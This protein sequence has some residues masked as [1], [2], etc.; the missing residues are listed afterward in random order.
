MTER[1]SAANRLDKAWWL[2][3]ALIATALY[4]AHW[5]DSFIGDDFDLIHSFHGKPTSYFPALLWNNESGDVWKSWGIDPELGRGYLRPIKIWLLAAEFTIWN[6]QAFGFHLTS[7]ACFVA[8]VLLVFAI[9]RRIVPERPVV[10]AAGAC[11]TAVHPIFAE[12]VPFITARE[13]LLAT[14]FGLASFFTFLRHRDRDSSPITFHL[15]YAC[16]LLTKE[17]AIVFLALPLG[18]D[19]VDGRLWPI[20]RSV[21]RD[22]F[23]T[24]A[25]SAGILTVYFALRW[26]AFGN[27]VG[28]DGYPVHYASWSA[29][30]GFHQQFWRSLVDPTLFTPGS[31]PWVGPVSAALALGLLTLVA[32]NFGNLPDQRRRDLWVLGPI[33]Y[34]GSTAILYG[35]YF[36]VRHHLLPIVG[37]VLFATVLID[38]LSVGRSSPASWK[39]PLAIL[40]VTA[41][42]F[43]PPTLRTSAD[44]RSA[45]SAVA[46]IRAEIEV[47][48]AELKAPCA[49]RLSGVPQWI[50]P[51]FYF[52]WGLQ[53]AL[54]RPFTD[55]DLAAVCTVI[56]ERNLQLTLATPPIPEQFDVVLEFDPK[57]WVSSAIE[58]RYLQ[59]L[60][61]EGVIPPEVRSFP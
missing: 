3:L 30:V 2:L 53:S 59:R 58:E 16:A 24:Y 21:V 8:I 1:I 11:A 35:T 27:F 22:L 18:R 56:D 15:T 45:S 14:A 13:E 42:L 51:P 20:S 57:R 38:S 17:S 43:L 39:W 9:L 4:A 26:L 44:W 10:A 33:W 41:G 7:S 37:L 25:P 19:L 28:G 55:S 60:W 12:I 50:Q 32:R 36:A 6:T 34:F 52:G 31:I 5:G 61:R 48:T 23:R 29:F 46:E 49:I 40:L 54:G 47:R